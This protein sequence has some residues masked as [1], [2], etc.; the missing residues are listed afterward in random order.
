MYIY[1]C[2]LRSTRRDIIDI[3][4]PSWI[5]GNELSLQAMCNVFQ[6]NPY[7]PK[8]HLELKITQI[9]LLR[10]K[11]CNII[12]IWWPFWIY[13]NELS[14]QSMCNISQVNSYVQKSHF[15]T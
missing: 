15:R 2:L 6:V 12:D 1:I 9:R 14:I 8:P 13:V 7:I 10:S 5:Y 4:W 11:T 3:W